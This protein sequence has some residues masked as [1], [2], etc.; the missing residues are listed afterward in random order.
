MIYINREAKDE[1]GKPIKPS[2][3]WFIE[4]ERLT[5]LAKQ[6]GNQHN[7]KEHYKDRK[8]KAALEKLFH[9]K[10]AYCEQQLT[11]SWDVEHFRPKKEVMEDPSHPGYYWLAYEWTNLYASCQ[12]CNRTMEDLPTWDDPTPGERKGKHT[13]FPLQNPEKRAFQPSDHLRRE[14]PLLLDPCEKGLCPESLI[15]YNL[16]GQPYPFDQHPRAAATIDICH[17]TRRRHRKKVETAIEAFIAR[18]REGAQ[19]VKDTCEFAGALRGV[20]DDPVRFGIDPSML[21]QRGER[22]SEPT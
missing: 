10:C 3:Q 16:L 9:R 7:V 17:L 21:A 14:Q 11:E 8:V 19:E 18:I 1:S 5:A 2:R 22:D 12:A 20:L 13:H 15:L 6:E 4:A